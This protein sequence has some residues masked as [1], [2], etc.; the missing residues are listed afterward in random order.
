MKIFSRRANIAWL[1]LLCAPAAL[2]AQQLPLKRDLPSASWAGCPAGE[3]P[4]E[5]P[6]VQRQSAD[7][8]AADATQAS[9]LGDKSA[10]LD[11]LTRAAAADPSS[12]PISYRL[13]R[14]LD[15][16]ERSADALAAYC[17][18]L[19]LAPD[20]PDA[21]D[22]R[23]RTRVL[24]TPPGFSVPA[25][26]VRAYQEGIAHFDAGRHAEAETA[27]GQASEAAPD[28][29]A[30]LY[31]RALTRIARAQKETAAEDLRHFLELSPGAPEFSAVLDLI[32]TL[33]Q[34]APRYNPSGALL[35]GL[36]VPGLGHFTT[37]RTGAGVFYL[38]TASSALAAGILLKK[39]DVD[40]LSVPVDGQC[41]PGQV[42]G[43]KETRPYLV[44]AVA[45]AL[46]T[47]VYG[48]ID[49]YRSAGRRNR[50][51]ASATRVG[52]D[53]RPRGPSLS[54]PAINVGAR[55][56]RLELIRVRF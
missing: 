13:A 21:Q 49:A 32:A 12:V 36:L 45:V 27:F 29:G 5:V 14:A 2:A 19:T 46:A 22:V 44:P 51:A 11:L 31:N 42:A 15:E 3:R 56:T 10:A 37:D 54:P 4:A 53:G 43:E 28:W 39:L 9:L 8:L 7:R 50:A 41:P 25:T 47:G 24:G 55:G 26:A 17:R 48:A 23:E 35:R 34:V 30:P 18:Y 33:R 20:S 16:L 38:A 1:M 6:T 52:Q 40:C